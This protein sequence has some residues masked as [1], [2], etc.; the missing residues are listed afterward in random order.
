MASLAELRTL[1]GNSELRNK[2]AAAIAI[3]VNTVMEGND[4]VPP[5]SQGA[6][7]HDLRVIYAQG[8]LGNTPGEA[9]RYIEVVLAKNDGATVVDI[10]AAPDSAIQTNV[11]ESFDLFAGVAI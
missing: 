11:D 3:S 4:N 9:K 2:I 7:D 6:G 10:L 1:Y 8:L 5:F